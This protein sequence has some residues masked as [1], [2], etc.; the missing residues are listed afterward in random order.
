[1]SKIS[2]ALLV[3][4]FISSIIALSAC[5]TINSSELIES[6]VVDSNYKGNIVPGLPKVY[7]VT[8]EEMHE[9]FEKVEIY[10]KKKVPVKPEENTPVKETPENNN[11]GGGHGAKPQI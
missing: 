5:Q 9:G 11:S 3:L 7:K 2:K 6:G 10:S 1:M 8:E 4:L